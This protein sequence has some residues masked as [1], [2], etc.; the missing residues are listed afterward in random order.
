MSRLAGR[1]LPQAQVATVSD[2]LP[3]A[4]WLSSTLV[5]GRTPHSVAITSAAV[6]LALAADE[7]GIDVAGAQLVLGGEPVTEARLAVIARSAS[8]PSPG[9]ARSRPVRSGMRASRPAAW[10]MSISSATCTR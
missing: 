7:A 10:T 1:P 8:S 5:A 3:F 4:R 9:T 2:P 6:R